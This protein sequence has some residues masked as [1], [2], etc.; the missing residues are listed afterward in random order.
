MPTLFLSKSQVLPLLDM[1][2]VVGVVEE[3]FRL[4]AWGNITM[5]SKSYLILDK[6]DFRAMP[7]AFPCGAGMK[8]VNVHPGNPA[9]GLPTVMA[10]IV[11][12][13]PE[14]GYPLAVM[15]GT[16][17][18]NYR[19][20]AASA[21]AS[22]YMARPGSRTLGLIGAGRQAYTQLAAHLVLGNFSL[23]KVYDVQSAAVKKLKEAFPGCP[24]E[25]RSL[26][27]AVASDIVCT[28]TP[29]RQPVVKKEWV[30]PGT[31]INAVGADAPGKEELEP[32][33][34]SSA[35][36]I[37]DDM[38]QAST[39]G[40]VNVPLSKGLLDPGRISGTLGEVVAGIKPG[41]QSPEEITV[42]DAT[43]LAFEDIACARLVYGKVKAK[44][45]YLWRSFVDG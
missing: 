1:K 11:Y 13:D 28:I 20:G 35:R 44:P 34:L 31:H 9:R 15:D 10:T 16:E 26:Q 42:F 17:I 27:D 21:V 14:T 4:M 19:T 36:I 45:G 29:A 8:W 38:K 23:I 7:A 18:T 25:E 33:I 2:E 37:V 43:G 39:S 12:N 32:A 22:K 41:R 30:R 3:A 24:L 40:E 6:G 5:P